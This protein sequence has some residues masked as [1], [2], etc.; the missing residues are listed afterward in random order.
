MKDPPRQ[1][2]DEGELVHCLD[3]ILR[4][5]TIGPLCAAV[6]LPILL[7]ASTNDALDSSPTATVS[8]CP[9]TIRSCN[10]GKT[11]VA[12]VVTWVVT[13]PQDTNSLILLQSL[14]R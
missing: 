5:V 10:H 6:N 11:S 12:L 1:P 14:S 4:G 9:E 13:N 8:S 2:L 7:I 3:G